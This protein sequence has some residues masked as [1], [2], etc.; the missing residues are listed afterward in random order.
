MGQNAGRGYFISG[1]RDEQRLESRDLETRIQEAVAAGQHY[2]SIDSFG[3]HG[4]GGR[5]WSAK[6][7]AVY[8]EVFGPPG[9][10]LGAM[11]SPNTTVEVFNNASD[12]VGWL[13]VGADIIIHGHAGNGV[14]NAMAQGRVFVGGNI[15]ARGMTMTKHNPRFDPPELWV[16]GSVGDYF[17]EFMAGGVAVVCGHQAQNPSNVLGYRPC[18]GMVGGKIFF[19]GPHEGYSHSDSKQIAIEDQDWKWL[20]KNLLEYLQGLGKE[21]LF[22][23]LAKPEDWQVLV[24]RSPFEKRSAPRLSMTAFREQVWDQEL[25]SGG[26]IGDINRA[27]RSLIPLITTGDLRRFIPAWENRKYAPPC[28]AVCP[29]GVP[30]HERWRLIRE[31]RVDEAVDLALLYTPFPATVCGYLCPN[32]CMQSCTRN[33]Q[34]MPPVDVK[35]LGQASL[36]ARLPELPPLS[37]SGV[38]VVGGGP[39]G[40]SVAWQLRLK[41]HQATVYDRRASLSG[42]IGEVIPK[43]RIPEQVLQTEMSR[44][45]EVLPRVNLQQPLKREELKQLREDYDFVVVATGS[46]VSKIPPIPGK[47]RIITALE[48]LAKTHLDQIQEV[49]RQVVI[50]GAGNVGCDVAVEANRLGAEEITLIDIQEPAAFGKEKESAEAIGVRFCWPVEASKVN[51]QGVVLSSGE[52]IPADTIV[53]A[54]GEVPETDIF[55]E[56][57]AIEYGFVSV[58]ENF[59]TTDPKVFAIGD[60]V[61]P[62]LITEAIGAGRR[63][64]LLID[65]IVSGRH[66]GAEEPEM[67][68]KQRITLEYFD[69]RYV[70]FDSLEQCAGECASC[71]SCRDCGLCVAICPQAAISRQTLNHGGFEMVVDPDRCIG[72]GFCAAACP[73]GIWNMVENDALI[74]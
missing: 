60:V 40:L 37:G 26:V 31:G 14:A 24:A 30:V 66:P 16:L 44:I 71:G 9:Q 18:V 6:D 50:L 54:I 58:N 73:C 5:L 32:L 3:Q 72:C 19:R 21:D 28:Q 29:T 20:K 10:R 12:D 47:E 42:K 63:V 17:A 38:A 11:G 62:G 27:D 13:N 15:G 64:A 4:I 35:R 23:V 55:P 22:P 43:T 52:I 51:D 70:C 7:D 69:P 53:A 39:A 56:T 67:I 33:S 46:S 1:G 48:F 34:D 49:G 57:V 65:D 61:K 2:L 74:E 68:D 59:Q 41:G 45:Q 8:I 36:Q 25:G